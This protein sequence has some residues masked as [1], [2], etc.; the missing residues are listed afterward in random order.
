MAG[1]TRQDTTDNISNGNI[2]DADD[3]DSE[4]NAVDDAFNSTTG[5]SHDGTAGEG[6]RITAAG[7]AGEM[8]VTATAIQPASDNA[9]D[10][11]TSSVEMKD[12]FFD[13]TI[14]TDELIVDE[15]SMF[16][17]AVTTSAAVS[18]GTNLTVASDL[19]VDGTTLHV[20]S[21]NNFVG[22]GLTNPGAELH[23]KASTP[24]VRLQPTS[25]VQNSRIEFTNAAGTIQSRIF[26]GGVNGQTIQ[27]DGN[28]DVTNSL[29]VTGTVDG[30]DVAADGTKLDG[31]EANATADQTAAEIRTLVESATNSNVFTDAD[32]SKLNGIENNATADQTAAEIR[33]LVGSA[34]DSNVFTDADHSKLNGIEANAT[35]DQ[36]AAEIRALVEAAINSNVFTDA[37]HTKLNGIEANATA[38]QSE[39]TAAEIRALVESASDSNVFTDADHSKLNGIAT[40]ADVTG[41]TN[42]TAAGALM[43]SEVTNLAQVKAFDSSDYATAAQGTL[44]DSAVQPNDSP[45]FGSVTVT[46]TVDGRD[47][48]ADGTKLDGIE[49]NATAD[50]TAAEIRTLV[51]SASNSNVFTDAD[52]TKLNGIEAN[53]TADQTA[54]EIRALVESASDSNVF[55]D[56]DHTKLNGI[57]TYTASSDY[58]MVLS[59]TEFRLDNDRRRNATDQ[60]IKSGNTHDFTEYD[61]AVGIKWYTAG[62]EEM[63]LENDGDLHVDGNITAYSTTVSDAR[64]KKDIVKIDGALDKVCSINGYTFTYEKDD[65]KS[66]GVIAQELEA[67]LPSAVTES[68]TPYHG[69]EGQMYK[70]VQYDQLHGLLIEAIKELKAEIED[71]KNG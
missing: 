45:A 52:H 15:T 21:T 39:L 65:K 10:L 71:L 4:F 17:G 42:V 44:A 43:D 38:D 51:E 19:T 58:G 62:A 35:A 25:D 2:I 49:A 41:T 26:G 40:S 53:A 14:K 69:E 23:I 66:A 60:N 64:L 6:A 24:Q 37:D 34:S 7:P 5:H 63:R 36:T 18:V 1:Y 9:L 27:L 31:I 30:R 28:V 11:G 59:G 20:D 54:A 29:S 46:G 12:G 57:A 33:T 22:I 48:A 47:V 55:T 50:Q 68:A 13:G 67:V 8:T 3:L 32:H 70:T 16:T 56:A 61:P